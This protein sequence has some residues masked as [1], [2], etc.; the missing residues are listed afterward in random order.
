MRA[1]V[2]FTNCHICDIELEQDS[3]DRC[4]KC[5]AAKC[6]ECGL[7]RTS[8]SRCATRTRTH[9]GWDANEGYNTEVERKSASERL[10]GPS[11]LLSTHCSYCC[12]S[13]LCVACDSREEEQVCTR[14]INRFMGAQNVTEK[15]T[16][17]PICGVKLDHK[18]LERCL[19]CDAI[20]CRECDVDQ[21]DCVK[22]VMRTAIHVDEDG[23]KSYT[24][25]VA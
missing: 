18:S 6:E 19:K 17:C 4:L 15:F 25:N 11:R 7:D 13:P 20:K 14:C 23:N 1:A 12:T 24:K 21:I 22:C 8:C 3:L 10:A 5:H 9:E 16:N 2:N